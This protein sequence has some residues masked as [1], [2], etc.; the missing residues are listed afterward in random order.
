MPPVNTDGLRCLLS[1]E[2]GRKAHKQFNIIFGDIW[3]CTGQSNMR[4]PM[5]E[6]E[7]HEDE[8]RKGL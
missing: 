7:N 2:S 4:M 5:G 1:I 6:V 8:I 3:V